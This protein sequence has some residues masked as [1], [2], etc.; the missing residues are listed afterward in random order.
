VRS[1]SEDIAS[2]TMTVTSSRSALPFRAHCTWGQ[3]RRPT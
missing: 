3:R 1:S 2:M